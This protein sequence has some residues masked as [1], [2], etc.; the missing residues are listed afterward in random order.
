MRRLMALTGAVTLLAALGGA[1]AQSQEQPVVAPEARALQDQP[2]AHLDNPILRPRF[3]RIPTE[4]DMASRFPDKALKMHLAGRVT[5]RC[6]V[7]GKGEL[8]NC[9]VLA[10]DPPD[11]GFG[12][13]TQSLAKVFRLASVCVDGTPTAGRRYT[14]RVT[15]RGPADGFPN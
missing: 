4:Q 3:L 9:E 1:R 15:W 7:T 8:T 5:A 13:A 10:E 14:F 6:L 12:A 2:A 11:Q